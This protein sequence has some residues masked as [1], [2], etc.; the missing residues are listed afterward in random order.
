MDIKLTD[1]QIEIMK[2]TIGYNFTNVPRKIGRSKKLI[3]NS[4]RN[5]YI[6]KR[7]DCLD[8]LCKLGLMEKDIFQGDRFMYS[9][10]DNGYTF[11]ENLL[12]I[13]IKRS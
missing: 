6:C 9:L 2:H 8:D 7:R 3:L 4:Y 12:D 11:M 13:T 1:E 10:S 5:H